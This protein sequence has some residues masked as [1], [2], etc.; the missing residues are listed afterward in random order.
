MTSYFYSHELIDKSVMGFITLL[1]TFRRYGNL[2]VSIGVANPDRHCFIVRTLCVH[3]YMQS[4]CTS[5]RYGLPESRLQGCIR[6]TSLALDTGFPAAM[7]SYFYSHELIDKSV[8]GF[9]TPLL[10]FRRYGN[11]NVSIGVANPDRH[12]R[13][14]ATININSL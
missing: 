9:I 2:N 1:L 14:S 3:C 11:L 6:I 4:Q 10:T 12:C 7:T 13:T 5:F 8:M